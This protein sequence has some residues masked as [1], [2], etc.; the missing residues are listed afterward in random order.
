MIPDP[1]QEPFLTVE[2]TARLLGLSRSAAYEAV[3]RG[4]IPAI[5]VSAHCLRVPTAA[6]WRMA[7]LDD[8]WASTR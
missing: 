4:T 2:A 5:R 1:Q 8:A 3:A 7:H 6:V